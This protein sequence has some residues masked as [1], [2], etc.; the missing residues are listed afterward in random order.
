MNVAQ[1]DGHR[2]LLD[3]RRERGSQA[4]WVTFPP[5]PLSCPLPPGQAIH[6][7]TLPALGGE[8]PPSSAVSAAMII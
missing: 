3:E 5:P 8:L 2:L 6:K 1:A 4:H 7:N